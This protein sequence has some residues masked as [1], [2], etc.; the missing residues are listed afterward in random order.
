MVNS[1]PPI[2]TQ[3]SAQSSDDVG[4]AKA[5]K[6]ANPDIVL[7]DQEQLP[8]ELLSKM[9]F[10]EI[11]GQQLLSVSRHDIVNGQQVI[12]RPISNVQQIAIAYNPG[13]II[14]VQD[15]NKDIFGKFFI[16]LSKRIPSFR[17]VISGGIVSFDSANENVEILVQNM[18]PGEEVEVQVLAAGAVFDDT[19]YVES[20]Q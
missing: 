6:I 9:I 3:L 5:I 20:V 1:I 18:A 10:E 17:E 19:I 2:G 11:S 12:Y 4:S 7:V 8:V 13:N 15:P 16:E 14:S